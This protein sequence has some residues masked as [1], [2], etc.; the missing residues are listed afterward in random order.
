MGV[1]IFFSPQNRGGW[2]FLYAL[3]IAKGLPSCLPSSS[4]VVNF[5]SIG[6]NFQQ[7]RA[8]VNNFLVCFGVFS[9]RSETKNGKSEIYFGFG[10]SVVAL[11]LGRW[12]CP[13]VAGGRLL[14]LVLL[15]CRVPCLLSA[16]LLCLWCIASEYGSI[17]RFKGVF[18]EFYGADVC[19]YGLR[20]LR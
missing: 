9:E 18:R 20:S 7:N 2:L 13:L 19:L 4:L 6:A 10:A 17:S 5:Q 1:Y 12:W 16:C 14:W 11:S 8:K 15:S 3:Y